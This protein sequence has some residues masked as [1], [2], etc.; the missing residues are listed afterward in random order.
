MLNRVRGRMSGSQGKSNGDPFNKSKFNADDKFIYLELTKKINL[1]QRKLNEGR[2]KNSK[3]SEAIIKKCAEKIGEIEAKHAMKHAEKFQEWQYVQWMLGKPV[4]EDQNWFARAGGDISTLD[5]LK[6]TPGFAERVQKI[7]DQYYDFRKF[8]A[9]LVFT[10]PI[11]DKQAY[12]YWKYIINTDMKGALVRAD[13]HFNM[14][15]FDNFLE[16]ILLNFGL[17]S[18]E[19]AEAFGYVP[20]QGTNAPVEWNLR[21]T[22]GWG[23]GQKR[24]TMFDRLASRQ[25]DD[26]YESGEAKVATQEA[27]E[28]FYKQHVQG[29]MVRQMQ[30]ANDDHPDNTDVT[31]PFVQHV[32]DRREFE[33]YVS[34][35]KFEVLYDY[36]AL[37][38]NQ[39]AEIK[40]ILESRIPR[41]GFGGGGNGGGNNPGNGGNNPG[42]GGNQKSKKSNQRKS[43]FYGYGKYGG[44]SDSDDDDDDDDGTG[45]G[46]GDGA[47]TT[48]TGGL[49][50]RVNIGLPRAQNRLLTGRAN[51]S[52]PISP[53]YTSDGHAVSNVDPNSSNY[54][55]E[56][57]PKIQ[58]LLRPLSPLGSTM[59]EDFSDDGNESFHSAN[60]IPHNAR[61]R[62]YNQ[63]RE[64]QESTGQ[65]RPNIAVYLD[66]DP[67]LAIGEQHEQEQPRIP[68]FI[69]DFPDDDNLVG[70]RG[71]NENVG[72]PRINLF[73][74]GEIQGTITTSH[75]PAVQANLPAV[76]ITNDQPYV[77]K[78]AQLERAVQEMSE[79]KN[80]LEKQIEN[81][82]L[83]ADEKL[84]FLVEQAVK[85][86]QAYNERIREYK[87][88]SDQYNQLQARN[89]TGDI[90]KLKDELDQTKKSIAFYLQQNEQLKKAK[91][92]AEKLVESTKTKAMEEIETLKKSQALM[93]R[94]LEIK[95]KEMQRLIEAKKK[96]DTKYAEAERDYR[97]NVDQFRQHIKE[98]EESLL[99]LRNELK[100]GQVSDQ[101]KKDLLL[102]KK[103]IQDELNRYKLLTQ[104]QEKA[105]EEIRQRLHEE[106]QEKKQFKVDA[107]V[108]KKI[109]HDRKL[110]LQEQEK[111][112]KER[113]EEILKLQQGQQ[114]QQ[115]E[116]RQRD[117][118]IADLKKDIEFQD[119]VVGQL[120]TEI[121]RQ[122]KNLDELRLNPQGSGST[123]PGA[124]TIADYEEELQRYKDTLKLE[125]QA[126][127]RL[128]EELKD[129]T[130]KYHVQLTE[131][132]QINNKLRQ[133]HDELQTERAKSTASIQNLGHQLQMERTGH[134]LTRN[135]MDN[136][137]KEMAK[138][139]DK[140]TQDVERLTRE[141]AN[142]RDKTSV[143]YK[144]LQDRLTA[145]QKDYDQAQTE[146][147]KA[148]NSAKKQQIVFEQ[149]DKD[150]AQA[151]IEQNK[152]RAVIQDREKFINN[153][154][155][156]MQLNKAKL[157]EQLQLMARTVGHSKAS[158]QELKMKED[159]IQ[160][161]NM[162]I[163]SY[164]KRIQELETERASFEAKLQVYD[165]ELSRIIDLNSRLKI[166]YDAELQERTEQSM[167]RIK[168]LE[169]EINQLGGSSENARRNKRA[170]HRE[171][172]ARMQRV[173]STLQEK[174][175][176]LNQ[177]LSELRIAIS[178]SKKLLTQ[179]SGKIHVRNM[180][181]ALK[182]TEKMLRNTIDLTDSTDDEDM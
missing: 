9:Q 30:E 149:K 81:E 23:N 111:I 36:L 101:V 136:L 21:E 137:S 66:D 107:E 182:T 150:I 180:H 166:E 99:V 88:L 10:G 146:I 147:E 110:K 35:D 41:R 175:K 133:Y 96:D 174:G 106:I 132:N 17:S 58:N 167:E 102:Q 117:K 18:D 6:L 103:E 79:T 145:L 135:M 151:I 91:E 159:Q 138:L 2:A 52:S 50:N 178:N 162:Q 100:N 85:L 154:V 179:G 11:N 130:I 169:N 171:D 134:E 59:Y 87:Q 4:L 90:Q 161:L 127:R 123:A 141:A 39:V 68:R 74:D 46:S 61:G 78:I 12:A 31:I 43:P 62:R 28:D 114:A 69:P 70:N 155:Q 83:Q 156:E 25:I 29:M 73:G 128:R 76:Q 92:D 170:R 140:H 20:Q 27:Y 64:I 16:Y 172:Q 158:E 26:R 51:A 163:E 89:T 177:K 97:K 48:S 34:R 15:N 33:K 124:M 139:R 37:L 173:N 24:V 54:Y 3:V 7:V 109:M 144:T 47:I 148:K 176:T 119:S 165:A 72:H 112:M 143:E 142:I 55:P 80:K 122:Q 129:M 95:D 118:I 160:A 131:H 153:K 113:E 8:L 19:L 56:D 104:E 98:L 152:L 181:N 32:W 14:E 94:D 60:P 1:E 93:T 120:K 22:I 126:A 108:S 75:A 164:E 105:I 115:S 49:L 84:Q 121:D 63:P 38:V 71:D 65:Q 5:T 57:D 67:Y 77:E 86:E 116:I 42:N 44:I 125:E 53:L 82:R 157:E 168:E 13:G 40:R 45:I